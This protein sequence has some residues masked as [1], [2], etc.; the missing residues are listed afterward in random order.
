MVP[1]EQF[2]LLPLVPAEERVNFD[3]AL[4]AADAS[5]YPPHWGQPP[6]QQ[7]R[8]LVSLPGYYGKGSGTLARWIQ[9]NLDSVTVPAVVGV[10][11][12]THGA[13]NTY[14]FGT[15]T[16]K[17]TFCNICGITSFYRPRSNPLGVGITLSCLVPQ[18]EC[19]NP[20]SNGDA[21][22]SEVRFFDGRNWEA[23]IEG[24]GI[25]MFSNEK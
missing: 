23:Y 12:A 5:P 6:L 15:H 25:K 14:T 11:A 20:G 8:D 7:S 17:H 4:A 21:S 24:S 1:S 22:T 16:A 18:V 13:I 19:G 3:D 9:E 10:E 2:T